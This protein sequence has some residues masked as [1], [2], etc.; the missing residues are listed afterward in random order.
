VKQSC[1]YLLLHTECTNSNRTLPDGSPGAEV[2]WSHISRSRRLTYSNLDFWQ[3]GDVG[4]IALDRPDRL[5]ALSLALLR[6]LINVAREIET[7]GLHTVVLTGNGKSFSSGVDVEVFG[8]EALGSANQTT[9]YDAAKLGGEMAD[10]IENLPQITVAALHGYVVGGGVVLA[11]ACDIR[12]ADKDTVF[13]IPEVDVGIPLAWGGIERLVREIGPTLT[14][15]LVMTCRPFTAQEARNAGFLNA[16]TE[17]GHAM[18][19]ATELATHIAEKPRL[20]IV[21]TKRH[22]AE[23]L[24]GDT[25]RDDAMGLLTALDDAESTAVRNAY[26]SR[27]ASES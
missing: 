8:S 15:E 18:E 27:F 21:T 17:P 5:N 7:S 24:N 1:A 6:E 10:A 20:P 26:T 14:K 2:R 3:D 13:I 12:V 19:V 4:F 9:R 16:L 22:I 11:A 23:V 25:S